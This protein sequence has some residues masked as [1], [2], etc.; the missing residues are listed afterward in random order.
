MIQHQLLAEQ[1]IQQRLRLERKIISHERK[2]KEPEFSLD[3]VAPLLQKW[4]V[5]W[6]QQTKI[7]ILDQELLQAQP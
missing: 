7:E 2:V 6:R 3:E 5:D 4:L 1:F